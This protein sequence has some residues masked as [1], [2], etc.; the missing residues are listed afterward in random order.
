MKKYSLPGLLFIVSLP[1]LSQQRVVLIEQ[2]T[3]SGC[4]PCASYTPQ[5]TQYA[6]NN[7]ATVVCIAYH[8]SFPYNDSMYFEN[9][10]ESNQRVGFYGVAAVP[11]SVMDGNQFNGSSASFVSTMSTSVPA[12]AAIVSPYAVAAQGLQISGNVLQGSMIFTSLQASNLSDSLRA[13]AVVIE[14]NV[15]KSAYLASPGNNTETV[16][17]YVMRKMLPDASGAVLQNRQQGGSDTVSL[18]WPL[19]HIKSVQEL[20]VVAFVQHITT[21][22]I[23]QA[24]IF[25][26]VVITGLQDMTTDFNPTIYPVPASEM[27]TVQTADPF[28]GTVDLLDL[29]GR[30]VGGLPEKLNAQSVFLVKL[31]GLPPGFYLLRF[32]NG[33]GEYLRKIA[34]Q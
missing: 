18:S 24:G 23:Y 14:K 8:T 27:I 4:P 7:P 9:P 31:Q 13:F 12:R 22:E 28:T 16:Y 11:F 5:V 15:Q 2:F 1:V 17:K 32:R 3:N 26:P 34:V 19:Q 33:E 20:R 29:A 10:V 6:D 30:Q 21:G 25:A